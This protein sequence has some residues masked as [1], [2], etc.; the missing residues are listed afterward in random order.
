MIQD[1]LSKGKSVEEV[2]PFYIDYL[3]TILDY[4]KKTPTEKTPT[5][6]TPTDKTPTGKNANG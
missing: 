3:Q 2:N 5:D 1:I 6:K 4:T